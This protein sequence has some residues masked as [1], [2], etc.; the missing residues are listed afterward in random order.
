MS[1]PGDVST[2]PNNEL[3]E[4]REARETTF[5]FD[6]ELMRLV[7]FINIVDGAEIGL[8]LHVGGCVVS[9]MLI[10]MAQFYRLLVK[11]F[12]DLN[13]LTEHSDRDAAASFAEFYRSPLEGAEKALDEYRK[14]QTLTVPPSPRHIH[15]R[16]AQTLVPGGQPLTQSL[17]RG[18]L[19]EVDGW[20]IGNFGPVPPLAQP[21]S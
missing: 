19:T 12:T 5:P 18:R 20:S 11:D 15:L 17:W 10:S 16:Y 9:G 21:D 6:P 4:V 13:R 2:S 3:E 8:T 1:E 7:G 14:S